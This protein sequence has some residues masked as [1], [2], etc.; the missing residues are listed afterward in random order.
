M[1]PNEYLH[2][3]AAGTGTHIVLVFLRVITVATKKRFIEA[4]KS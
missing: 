4:S 1:G 3:D 2:G